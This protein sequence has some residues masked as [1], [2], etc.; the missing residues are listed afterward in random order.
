MMLDAFTMKALALFLLTAATTTSNALPVLDD[1]Q[2][3]E[4]G[5]FLLGAPVL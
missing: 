4:T 2:Y 5:G 1:R 3:T